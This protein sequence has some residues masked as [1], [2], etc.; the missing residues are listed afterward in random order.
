MQLPLI[1]THRHHK[2]EKLLSIGENSKQ[3]I[4]LEGR[5]YFRNVKMT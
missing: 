3:S 2:T 1:K 4:N 5:K